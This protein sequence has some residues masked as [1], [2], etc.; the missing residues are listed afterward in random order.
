MLLAR[1]FW[2]NPDGLLWSS[3]V[4]VVVCLF[5]VCR[6]AILSPHDFSERLKIWN[7]GNNK[8]VSS[9]WVDV[10]QQRKFRKKTFFRPREIFLNLSHRRFFIIREYVKNLTQCF[11]ATHPRCNAPSALC[12]RSFFI[13]NS[14]PLRVKVVLHRGLLLAQR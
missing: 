10:Q 5:V 12:A 11:D 9:W 13:L 1:G 7:F 4:F 8:K 14:S 6:N 3:M 2:K